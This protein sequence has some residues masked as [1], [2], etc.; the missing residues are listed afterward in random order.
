MRNAIKRESHKSSSIRQLILCDP[1]LRGNPFLTKKA[2]KRRYTRRDESIL[3]QMRLGCLVFSA[4]FW[5][6]DQ[7]DR[8]CRN[9]GARDGPNHTLLNCPE[10]KVSQARVVLGEALRDARRARDEEEREKLRWRGHVQ[11]RPKP[12]D[13][14]IRP[15]DMTDFPNEVLNF[16]QKSRFWYDGVAKKEMAA[17][18]RVSRGWGR[19]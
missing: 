6:G 19:G 17:K 1:E 9:C 15:R 11:T 5:P 16:L 14:R 13:S 18:P 12:P 8:M 3:N 4:G 2:E 10:E 7:R